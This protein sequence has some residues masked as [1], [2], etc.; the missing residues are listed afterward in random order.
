MSFELSIFN[1]GQAGEELE[2]EYLE[3]LVEEK[4]PE[5]QA[6]FGKMWEYY[7][8]A[9]V[10]LH[11]AESHTVER[12]MSESGKCY[13]QAQEYGLPARITGVTRCAE[14]GVFGGRPIGD[15]QR[16]EV[17][18]ENDIA[19]RI[20]AAVD[21]LFGKPVSIVSRSPDSAKRAEVEGILKAVFS[22]NGGIG[23]FQDMAVLGG[24]Y[25][26]V[27]CMVRPGR[28]IYEHIS[29]PTSDLSYSR[30]GRLPAE[31]V[32]Q[33]ARAIGLELIEAP[34][35]LPVL[36]END[37]RRVIYYVQHF[38][39]AKNQ[40]AGNTNL[41]WKLLGRG[42]EKRQVVN[43][44]EITSAHAWQRYEDKEL[45]AEGETPWGFL[46]VVHIQNIAQPFYYEGQSDVEPLVP[47]QDELN[48]RLSDRASRITMQ[49]FKMYLGK[50][51]EQFAEK[52]VSPGVMWCTDNQDA[53]IEEFG[54]DQENPSEGLHISEMR[55]AMDKVSGVTPLVAGVIR[56]RLGNLTSAIAL[57]LTMMGTL[58]K[59]ERKRFTYGEGIKR[60]AG[61]VL[62]I[63][64]KANIYKTSERD[65]EVEIIFPDPLPENEM[66]KLNEAKAKK[67]LG[68][69]VERVLKEL[70]YE[71]V[72]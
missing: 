41:L 57:R 63:L 66:E 68:V 67:E 46:P 55:E 26:F 20:N 50:G 29:N 42:G 2:A 61:M 38:Q 31:V 35:A 33:L 37:Y 9:I 69:P 44:T 14:A 56:S 16:K 53:S 11:R 47:I 19:W 13:V 64:D 10:D 54:G 36:D 40:L 62:E 25:G 5:I 39:Q 21:F 48:T 12:K 70:G 59:T 17:V 28:E 1:Q 49:S 60:I 34:R 65:R 23:F 32:L 3:W 15:V 43:V 51:I 8:N 72:V 18:I 27:D 71:T 6:H 58:S 30:E 4:W 24:I 22:A 45:V 52:P 7:A